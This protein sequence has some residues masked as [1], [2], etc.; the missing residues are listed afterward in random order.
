MGIRRARYRELWKYLRFLMV[1]RDENSQ[2]PSKHPLGEVQ[3]QASGPCDE[4]SVI[5]VISH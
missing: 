5:T 2:A 4:Y 3:V 1:E